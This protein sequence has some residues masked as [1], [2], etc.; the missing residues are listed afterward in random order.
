METSGNVNQHWQIHLDE[1]GIIGPDG[2]VIQFVS[3]VDS[4]ANRS[5]PVVILDTGFS[6]PQVPQSVA[7]AFYKN[8]TGAKLENIAGKFIRTIHVRMEKKN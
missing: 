4:N 5:Q 8:I 3:G 2:N 1:S 6:L 7:D